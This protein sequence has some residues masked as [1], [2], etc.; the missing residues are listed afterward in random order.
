MTFI[1][2]NNI[3]GDLFGGVTAGIVA[4]PLALASISEPKIVEKLTDTYHFYMYD[5]KPPVVFKKTYWYLMSN[6]GNGK[7]NP[8]TEEGITA[9]LW[10]DDGRIDELINKTHRN[11][12][13]LFQFKKDGRI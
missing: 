4:L 8:Q 1:E 12:K 10:V 11:L 2:T 7:T 13:I 9:C 6:E 5:N 3:K